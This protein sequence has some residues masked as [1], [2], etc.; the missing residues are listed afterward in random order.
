MCNRMQNPKIKSI[1]RN[2]TI[3][4]IYMKDNKIGFVIIE[5]EHDYKLLAKWYTISISQY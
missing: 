5:K 2:S 4:Y 1:G 3:I